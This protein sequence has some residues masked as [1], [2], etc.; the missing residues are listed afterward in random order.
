M[1]IYPIRF[2][3]HSNSLVNLYSGPTILRTL[4]PGDSLELECVNPDA[5]YSRWDSIDFMPGGVRL[6]ERRGWKEPDA[7]SGWVSVEILNKDGAELEVREVAGR[8]VFLP[9]YIPVQAHI[10]ADDPLASAARVEIRQEPRRT[11][12]VYHPGYF[13][14][15]RVL[16]DVCI[17][18]GSK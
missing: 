18:R 1:T 10:P 16:A 2:R 9:R 11:K 7:P 3:N 12:S 13:Q 17:P 15:E 8:Q 4:R 5:L 14:T 6:H